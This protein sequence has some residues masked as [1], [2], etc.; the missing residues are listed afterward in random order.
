MIGNFK[1][2]LRRRT[3]TRLSK[4]S[5]YNDSR[6]QDPAEERK[7]SVEI[8][9]R[10]SPRADNYHSS[11]DAFKKEHNECCDIQAPGEVSHRKGIDQIGNLA[12]D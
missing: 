1:L 10:F 5:R 4:A 6:L 2:A 3:R 12:A 9:N 11:W 8:N 7:Y